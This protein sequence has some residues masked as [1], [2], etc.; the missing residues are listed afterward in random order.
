MSDAPDDLCACESCGKEFP[1]EKMTMMVE[2]WFCESCTAEWRKG[3]EACDH[4]WVLT[5][6]E[7]SEPSQYCSKC[8]GLVRNEDFDHLFGAGSFKVLS[9]AAKGAK[10]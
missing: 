5:T 2:C 4:R 7:H 1:Y 8:G 6:N 3:F 9:A 10:P